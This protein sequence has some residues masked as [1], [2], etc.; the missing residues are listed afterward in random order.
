M[1][2][3]GRFITA[4]LGGFA[5]AVALLCVTVNFKKLHFSSYIPFDRF[6]LQKMSE[7]PLELL[8]LVLTQR[9]HFDQQDAIMFTW[10]AGCTD[11]LF[12]VGNVGISD[13]YQL[14]ERKPHVYTLT[15][16]VE[17]TY[18]NTWQKLRAALH[19]VNSTWPKKFDWLMRID[20][21]AFVIFENLYD[22]LM[23][24]D[25]RTP[26]MFGAHYNHYA[27]GYIGT[28]PGIIM[29]RAAFTDLMSVFDQ[30]KYCRTTLRTHDDDVEL[31]VC[32]KAV[33]VPF[34]DSSDSKGRPRFI[35]ISLHDLLNDPQAPNHGFFK[36]ESA[37][38]VG[39]GF[40]CCADELIALHYV[41][42]E[43]MR[44]FQR[45]VSAHPLAQKNL[46]LLVNQTAITRLRPN[47][48]NS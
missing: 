28:G 42:A 27:G 34:G 21:D 38:P 48:A 32:L 37:Y 16:K 9:S 11:L 12:I 45:I 46:R 7:K 35:P 43:E 39:E 5:I 1:N 2:P 14:I 24:K 44:H 10:G 25:P 6:M 41:K 36:Q 8:C 26:A 30:K 4:V 31:G 23:A 18:N 22:F 19:F 29:S 20:D 47:A 15:V 33:K 17:D 40:D 3:T 13:S